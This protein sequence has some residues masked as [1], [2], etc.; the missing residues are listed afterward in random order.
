MIGLHFAIFYSCCH[1]SVA[2]RMCIHIIKRITAAESNDFLLAAVKTVRSSAFLIL[3]TF[4]ATSYL[5]RLTHGVIRKYLY[6][7]HIQYEDFTFFATDF[8]MGNGI[9]M[10]S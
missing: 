1:A 5:I 8:F 9:M 2:V 10:N 4:V 7:V 3:K 6:C